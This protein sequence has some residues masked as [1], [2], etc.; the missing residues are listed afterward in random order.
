[1]L[2]LTHLCLLYPN[3]ELVTSCRIIV[4]F[5]PHEERGA[6]L[7][8]QCEVLPAELQPHLKQLHFT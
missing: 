2:L 8:L 4:R 6:G 7:R 3:T 5:F 1:M